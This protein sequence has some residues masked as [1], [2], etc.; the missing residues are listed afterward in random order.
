MNKNIARVWEV[1]V[2]WGDGR[3]SR[4]EDTGGYQVSSVA[5]VGYR[6]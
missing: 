1:L 5:Q 6:E 4:K 3:G 2:V